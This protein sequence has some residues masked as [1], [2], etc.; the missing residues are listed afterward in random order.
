MPAPLAPPTTLPPAAPV[1]PSALQASSQQK[2]ALSQAR[3]RRGWLELALLS[4]HGSLAEGLDG[5]LLLYQQLA[6]PL[7][8]ADPTRLPDV[9]NRLTQHPA[10]PLAAEDAERLYLLDDVYTRLIHGEAV[11]LSVESVFGWM[12]V[13]SRVLTRYGV[14]VATP[15]S[16]PRIAP[17]ATR[18]APHPI[19]GG[20]S[21][22]LNA[23]PRWL[24]PTL[25]AALIILLATGILLG[26]P[27][28]APPSLS[29]R[30]TASNT[31]LP[32]IA[33]LPGMDGL[34]AGQVAYVRAD[35][36]DLVGLQRRPGAAASA[37]VRLNLASDTAVQVIAGP[38][39]ADQQG[40]W[41]VRV[42]NQDGWLRGTAL[43]VR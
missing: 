9:L 5:Y 32:S 1:L 3:L 4:L 2:F 39:I 7:A 27:T 43:E 34:Q 26:I 8:S 28:S 29:S 31:D 6:V 21:T 13:A 19:S 24:V 22:P 30:P 37:E 38:V 16:L 40:W 11:V 18:P 20:A 41:Q 14:V 15:E 23:P 36:G 33:N 17:E 12:Q 10:L 25:L 42:F 35:A